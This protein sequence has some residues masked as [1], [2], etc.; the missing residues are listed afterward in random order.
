MTAIAVLRIPMRLAV[1]L[2]LV[3]LLGIGV[4]AGVI[5]GSRGDTV[6]TG[7]QSGTDSRGDA[8]AAPVSKVAA[9]LAAVDMLRKRFSTLMDGDLGRIRGDY[10]LD[11]YG[12]QAAWD[13]ESSRVE[14]F[15]KW[16]SKRGVT[17]AE[18]AAWFEVDHVASWSRDE[19]RL[20]VTEHA[21]YA[22]R[23]D[24]TSPVHRF[25]SRAVHVM[26]V[27][28]DGGQWL[29]EQDWYTDPLGDAPGGPGDAGIAIGL[30][31]A[32]QTGRYDRTRAVAYAVRY[33]GVRSLPGGGRY[34]RD[35]TVYSY[36]GGDCA[37]FASQVMSAGGM[38]MSWLCSPD[39]IWSLLSSGYGT[40]VY[41]GAFE[42][43]VKPTPEDP[44]GAIARMEPGDIIAYQVKGSMSHVAVVT[45]RD[46][47]GYPV[48]ASHTSDRLFFPWDLG[49]GSQTVF[50]LIHITY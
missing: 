8:V 48:V 36:Q 12:G 27:R 26:V 43:A 44:S 22:Y 50:W 11:T 7:G 29:I 42:G 34:N 6:A 14:Y 28:L 2:G 39:L 3:A 9:Q 19:F 1:A 30:P 38:R 24:E 5:A 13:R 31:P 46:P 23:L 17:L 25:G 20:E 41:S 4:V 45:G 18:S 47:Y 49:W 33:S 21:T 37:N 35:Y 32:P 40:K 10:D 16:L 15:R